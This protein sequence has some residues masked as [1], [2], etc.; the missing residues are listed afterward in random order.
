MLDRPTTPPG[1]DPCVRLVTP[2]GA[3]SWLNDII[4]KVGV[5]AKLEPPSF[6]FMVPSRWPGQIHHADHKEQRQ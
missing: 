5:L 6:R 4:G 2:A 3:N 1:V